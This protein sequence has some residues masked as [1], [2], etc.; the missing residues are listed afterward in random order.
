MVR[1]ITFLHRVFVA[2]M[3]IGLGIFDEE[4]QATSGL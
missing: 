1:K 3:Q 2:P 4:I